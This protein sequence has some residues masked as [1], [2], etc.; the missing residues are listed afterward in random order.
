MLSRFPPYIV[1]A[2]SLAQPAGAQ[3]QPLSAIDWIDS[4]PVVQQQPV[5][6]VPLA[7]SAANPERLPPDVT[8]APLNERVQR[9]IGLVPP[10][11]T[12][13]PPG[14]WAGSDPDVLSTLLE[15]LPD[16]RLP[17]AQA[18]LYRA[19]LTEAYGPGDDAATEDVFTLARARVLRRSGALE[20]ALALISQSGPVR[21]KDHFAAF[22][23]LALLTGDEDAA[24]ALL[25][26]RP[27]LAPSAGHRI[28]C[29]LRGGDW[30]T[31]AVLYDAGNALGAIAPSQV[32]LL[33]RFLDPDLF[34]GD[35][36]L[37]PPAQITPLLFRLH[38][39][40]GEPLPTRFLPRE[41]AVADLRDL[42]GW[43]AQLEAAERLSRAGSLPDNQLLGLYTARRPAASGGVWD[44]ASAV[45]KLEAALQR[46]SVA[47]T[48]S[49]L[50][51]AWQA[52]QSARL[53]VPFATLFTDD[54]DR[55]A[56]TGQPAAIAQRM[57]LLSPGF[58]DAP[59]LPGDLATAI[60][61]RTPL[62]LAA[63]TARDAA[64]A[65]AFSGTPR[66]DKS[67]RQQ[68]GQTILTTLATL[69]DGA[70]GDPVALQQALE[71]LRGLGFE[72]T[73]RRAAL[74]VL[75][76]DRYNP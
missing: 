39:A 31:A 5:A 67:D 54:L 46:P 24:C 17:A 35:P 75:L 70:A 20:P 1:A 11:V 37:A 55:V 42:A 10:D 74:Q 56:L 71:T 49:A 59:A 33:A 34:E 8:V 68:L 76:L 23:D 25:T 43:K 18:L 40:I 57:R 64:I 47:E 44:R 45:Q 72:T 21:D 50:P 51:L 62:P 61:R 26:D 6:S 4:Q 12:G 38:E 32:N 65:A 66:P 7:P 69:E 60:A 22:M 14:L 48:A 73:A 2:L 36:A 52:M 63:G 29:T 3:D 9:Q 19:V 28:F 13:L 53:E 41:Y 27:H 16:L 30:A 58:E 15:R